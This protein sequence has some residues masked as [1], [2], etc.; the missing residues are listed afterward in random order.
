MRQSM[1]A[2]HITTITI[3]IIG[4]LA[5]TGA[6]L[7]PRLTNKINKNSCCQEAGGKWENNSCIPIQVETYDE[8][9]YNNCIKEK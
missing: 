5:V 7:I 1:G 3:I 9:E 4:I 2:A 8:E 6:V